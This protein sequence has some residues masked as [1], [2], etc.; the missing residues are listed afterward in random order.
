MVELMRH[1]MV[2]RSAVAVLLS[3]GYSMRLPPTVSRVRCVS[4]L[5][6]RILQTRRPYVGILSCETW[7]LGINPIVLVPVGILVPT[8]LTRRPSS[9]AKEVLQIAAALVRMRWRYSKEAPVDGS[10]TA[11]IA[12][13]AWTTAMMLAA[14]EYRDCAGIC[15]VDGVH[16]FRIRF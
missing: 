16:K 13:S 10:S 9:L 11:F 14:R 12:A 4:A 2:V 6:W 5:C 7:R 15:F 3:P 8:P 1:L